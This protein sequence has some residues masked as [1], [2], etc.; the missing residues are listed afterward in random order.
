MVNESKRIDAATLKL[1]AS[2]KSLREIENELGIEVPSPRSLKRMGYPRSKY[3]ELLT[4]KKREQNRKETDRFLDE[5]E[6]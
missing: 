6:E 5:I 2:N 4:R 1:W 3:Y